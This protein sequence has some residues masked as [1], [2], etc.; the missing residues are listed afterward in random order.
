MSCCLSYESTQDALCLTTV[1]LGG[2]C[3]CCFVSLGFCTFC[4]KCYVLIRALRRCLSTCTKY[5][6]QPLRLQRRCQWRRWEALRWIFRSLFCFFVVASSGSVS[7]SGA[8]LKATPS[9]L[10]QAPPYFHNN[11]LIFAT[12]SLCSLPS[13]YFHNHVLIVATISLFRN[14]FQKITTSSLC[15]QPSPYIQNHV[16]ILTQIS[17]FLQPSS[18]FSQPFGSVQL[19]RD[20]P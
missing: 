12:I 3:H 18:L 17:R 1:S 16:L 13:P 5:L 4:R 15:S 8:L 7:K 6:H 14:N 19:I 11:F 2:T 10:L 9:D 20:F